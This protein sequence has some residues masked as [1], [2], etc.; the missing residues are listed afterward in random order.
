MIYLLLVFLSYGIFYGLVPLTAISLAIATTVLIIALAELF[1]TG[2]Q[3]FE[4]VS[5][6]VF[7]P[8][9]VSASF[10]S[11]GYFFVYRNDMPNVILTISLFGLIWIN[12]S[13]AYL[14]GRSIGRTKLFERLSPNKTWEGSLGGMTCSMIVAGALS[15]ID[16]MPE[17]KTMLGFAIVCVIFGSLG[18]LF[19]SRIKRAADVKDSGKFLPGHGGFFDRFDAMMFAIPAS[20]IYFEVLLPK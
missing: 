14:I 3:P 10:L 7:A 4:N 11:I 2:S 13:G 19:E 8:L 9:F 5:T 6:S 16:G 17:I 18:D 20:I 12:D 15:Y 1:R